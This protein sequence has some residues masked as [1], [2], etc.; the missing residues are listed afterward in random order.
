M[1]GRRVGEIAAAAMLG[2]AALIALFGGREG[3][4]AGAHPR[5]AADEGT[6]ALW[7][8]LERLGAPVE[9]WAKEPE[10]LEGTGNLLLWSTTEGAA[11]R[12]RGDRRGAAGPAPLVAWVERGNTL[13][14]PLDHAS[15]AADFLSAAFGLTG[16]S[17]AHEDTKIPRTGI[18][19]P[20]PFDTALLGLPSEARPLVGDPAEPFAAALP[21]G[22]GTL[23]LLA[24]IAPLSN[25]ALRVHPGNLVELLPIFEGFLTKRAGARDSGRFLLDASMYGDRDYPRRFRWHWGR[26]RCRPR[27]TWRSQSWC[28]RWRAESASARCARPSPGRSTT[29]SRR[30][31]RSRRSTA[32]PGAPSSPPRRWPPAS[33]SGRGARWAFP[34]VRDGRARPPRFGRASIPN[35]R[36]LRLLT[37]RP[38][39]TLAS[40]SKPKN[41]SS[42][43]GA[44][45]AANPGDRVNVNPNETLESIRRSVRKAIVGLD[46]ALD[47]SI[48]AL[49]CGGHVL[50]EGVPGSRRHSW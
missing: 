47:L 40:W 36:A 14:V 31:P 13:A 17:A 21:R 3:E 20:Q 19:A 5:S 22:R 1:N 10:H 32:A 27:S 29:K 43:S 34:T 25:G 11:S 9:I 7:R 24:S 26:A 49:L 37:P 44:S 35:D 33:P 48:L 8:T 12:P 45:C 38:T 50:L 4:R 39:A 23:L 42:S 6:R 41:P 16:I 46:D 18:A 2:M 15:S 28:S 30:P